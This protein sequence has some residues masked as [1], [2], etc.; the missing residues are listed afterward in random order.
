[1][2]ISAFQPVLR[3]LGDGLQNV[4]PIT[5]PFLEA[6]HVRASLLQSPYGQAGTENFEHNPPLLLEYGKDYTITAEGSLHGGSL[7]SL[8]PQ[9]SLLTIWLDVPITQE[10]VL[11]RSGYLSPPDLELAFDKQ[12]LIAAQLAQG[13]KRAVQVPVESEE[14]PQSLLTRLFEARDTAEQKARA[15]ALSAASTQQD[16][17]FCAQ[18]LEE[19]NLRETEALLHITETTNTARATLLAEL[20]Q[21]GAEQI[22]LA[23]E[24]AHIATQQAL[25][26]TEAA[27]RIED[28]LGIEGISSDT[29]LDSESFIATS[30]AVKKACDMAL[31][32]SFPG[33]VIPYAG[34]FMEDA[35]T[36][37]HAD[38]GAPMLGWRLC[39]GF[40]GTP[41]LR[42]MF[43]RG[44]SPGNIAE[45]GGTENH[46]H[47]VSGTITNASATGTINAS[48]LTTAQMPA[49]NHSMYFFKDTTS[50]SSVPWGSVLDH[51]TGYRQTFETPQSLPQ[52]GVVDIRNAMANAGS[53]S[54]HTHT[55]T[56][57]AHSHL[58]QSGQ[59]DNQNTLP[60]YYTL[61][62]IMRLAKEV[63]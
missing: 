19:M 57:A 7:H 23:Q 16:S 31:I 50:G 11:T 48:T 21:T 43:I 37:R 54:S 36:P 51:G 14:S 10:M 12:T 28:V 55:L 17:A 29:D 26:A 41:D 5:F 32:A 18:T 49:H 24:Q 27:G 60:P 33:M 35:V 30:S 38:T 39:N 63:L 25:L 52:I 53:S 34:A 56:P 40:G 8:V 15:A 13:L 6:T 44:S 62:Y 47:T 9:D 4:W 2:A 59:A 45:T 1:M 3:Y 46:S 22:A 20:E 61:C 42:G 58:L